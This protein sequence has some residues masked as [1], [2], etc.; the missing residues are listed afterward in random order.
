M[1]FIYSSHVPPTCLNKLNILCGLLFGFRMDKSRKV[2]DG[3]M[4]MI[5]TRHVDPQEVI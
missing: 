3:Q 4:R 2:N 5:G 1:C